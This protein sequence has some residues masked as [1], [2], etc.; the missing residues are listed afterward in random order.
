MRR[1]SLKVVPGTARDVEAIR[2][3]FPGEK[4]GESGGIGT[5]E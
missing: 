1:L 3:A 4:H 2:V 5:R